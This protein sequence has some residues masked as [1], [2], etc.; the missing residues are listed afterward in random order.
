M[1]FAILLRIV[2]SARKK[3][4]NKAIHFTVLLLGRK[5][6]FYVTA[7]GKQKDKLEKKEARKA[8]KQEAGETGLASTRRAPPTQEELAGVGA[9]FQ[10]G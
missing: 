8:K 1:S 2:G 5:W 3:K 9:Y 6:S 10:T 4:R 7:A